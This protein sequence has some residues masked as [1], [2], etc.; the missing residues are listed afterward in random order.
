MPTVALSPIGNAFQFLSSVGVPLNGGKLN[1]YQAGTNNPLST[2][3]TNLGTVSNANPI[4]FNSDGR[5]PSEVWLVSGNSYKF[6]LTDSLNTLIATYDNIP[7]INDIGFTQSGAGAVFQ[8]VTSKLRQV[9]SVLDFGADPTGIADATTAFNNAIASLPNGGEI[10]VVGTFL[11]NG[12]VTA[13][14]NITLKGVFSSPPIY[15]PGGNSTLGAPYQVNP[16]S[17]LMLGSAATISIGFSC[18]L[19][20]L[21]LFSTQTYSSGA[22]LTFTGTAI[23]VP[24]NAGVAVNDASIRNCGIF[25]FNTAISATYANRLR[26]IDL[27]IDCLNG[28]L[29]SATFDTS[30]FERIKLWPFLNYFRTGTY[31]LSTRAGTAFTIS[32]CGGSWHQVVNCAAIGWATGVNDYNC[33]TNVYR[34]CQFDLYG[35]G[36]RGTGQVA[37]NINGSMTGSP[38]LIED[39]QGTT[40]TLVSVTVSGSSN[41]FPGVIVDNL[42]GWAGGATGTSVF[43]IS[44][45]YVHAHRVFAQSYANIGNTGGFLSNYESILSNSGSAVIGIGTLAL[46][47]QTN[48]AQNI[49]AIGFGALQSNTGGTNN[50]GIGTN[51]LNAITVSANGTA[52]GHSALSQAT[53]AQNVALGSLAGNGLV[54]GADCVFIGYNAQPNATGDINEIVVGPNISGKGN[55]TAFIG[56]SSGAYNGANASTWATVSDLRIKE[57]IADLPDSLAAICGLRPVAFKYRADKTSD[58]GFIAQ[59]Y[60]SIFPDQVR[61]RATSAQERD[62]VPDGEI[63]V[64]QQNL[65][66]YFVR[67]IQELNA[68]IAMLET[69]RG[70]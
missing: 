9:V 22:A 64:I 6:T 47:N 52:I 34:G 66:P 8:S 7:A 21:L 25:G 11:I 16:T 57:N 43:N 24:G 33:G 2:F 1:T 13:Q 12:T 68:R 69:K 39:C 32:G 53:G 65:T 40:D 35:A 5:P 37:F 42:A 28:V 38:T 29:L 3:T 60:K 62:L 63:L 51:T 19:N 58:I 10:E 61:E 18:S 15:V 41:V 20:G 50:V 56:G 67:A 23:T 36:G 27:N 49:V 4:I 70:E 48:S 31:P 55:N 17:V 44:T 45:G 46:A 54:T 59:E 30:Y 14:N 26:C